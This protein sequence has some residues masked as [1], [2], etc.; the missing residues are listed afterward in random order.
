MRVN[1]KSVIDRFIELA[2]IDGESFNE[3]LVADY[4][5]TEFQKLGVQLCEDDTAAKIGGKCGNLYGFAEGRGKYADSEPVLFCAHMDTV[6]P[7]NNK[8]IIINDDGTIISDHTTVLGA[9]DRVGIAGI[10]EAYTGVLKEGLDHPPIEFLFTVSEE[11][12]GLGSAALD[13]SRIRSRI[14]FAPDCSGEYGVYSSCEPTLISFEVHIKGKASHAGYEPEKGINAIAVA[15]SAISRIKQGWADD[16]TTLNIGTIEGGSVTNA[17]PENCLIKGE[18]RSGVHE[19]A[20]RI[21]DLVESI[22]SEEAKRAGAE[23]CIDKKERISVYRKD[24]GA[25]AGSALD[26]YKRALEKQGRIAAAKKSFGGSDINSLIKNG[27]DGL[28]IYG[29]MHNIHTT[30]EYTTV[31][32]IVDF[33]ELIKILMTQT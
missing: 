23:I 24:P 25:A 15:A 32:E 5:I 26:R 31:Q 8:K 13:Y 33:T 22:F 10:I 29:P 30:E 6:A 19:D 9:D 3:R 18:I 12:Y 17:V 27:I 4:L 11:V 1:E 20:Y 7:G 21:M 28:N 2:L 14:A 16:H